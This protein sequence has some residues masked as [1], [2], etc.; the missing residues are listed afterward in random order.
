MIPAPSSS[1]AWPSE[2][3]EEIQECPL[4][5]S[6]QRE[7][8]HTAMRDRIFFCAPGEWTIWFCKNCECAYL[9]PRP[10][11]TSIGRAYGHYY[12]HATHSAP[13]KRNSL[14]IIYHSLRFAFFMEQSGG[15]SSSFYPTRFG[16]WIVSKIFGN[17][18]K[19]HDARLYPPRNGA[20]LLDIG[21]GGGDYLALANSIGWAAEGIDTDPNAVENALAKGCKARCGS[22]EEELSRSAGLYD[23]I[24]LSHVIE[25]LHNPVDTLKACR[26]LL[27]P[28]GRIWLATP[29]L[30][31]AGHRR[32][33]ADW[34]HLDPPRHLVLFTEENLTSSLMAAG[35]LHPKFNPR[36][37]HV[38]HVWKCSYA[39]RRGYDPLC[40]SLN[41]PY[42][43]RLT[44][45]KHDLQS[46][47][48]KYSGD[49][50]IVSAEIESDHGATAN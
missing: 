7:V 5:G 44:A 27:R 25:H 33:G 1:E 22:V 45:L 6:N 41:L 18:W 8:L 31:S 42:S 12:T 4:C 49:E 16:A 10:K 19:F 38:L 13:S 3:L 36:G 21:C 28:G 48:S 34:L 23:A 40:N 47:F 2:D 14:K 15:G 29:R 20:R 35:F 50:I 17:Q 26:H 32:F 11:V 30:D 39:I 24:T 37:R 46:M 9:S 43:I